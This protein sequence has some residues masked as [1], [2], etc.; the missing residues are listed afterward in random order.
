[1]WQTWKNTVHLEKCASP[2]KTAP[3]FEKQNTLEKTRQ[4]LKKAQNLEICATLAKMRR[5]G[6][7]GQMRHTC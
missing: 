1:V 3:S 4:H 6:T 7:L 5:E 2:A